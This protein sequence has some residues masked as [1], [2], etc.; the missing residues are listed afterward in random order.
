MLGATLA[1]LVILLFLG[2]Q[3][4]LINS[5]D[6][7]EREE[8]KE[9][10]QNARNSLYWDMEDL[11]KKTADWSV[12]DETYYFVRDNNSNYI[13][14]YLVDET[15][16]NQR[17]SFVLF[18]NESGA[19]V[20][21]KGMDLSNMTQVPP[22]LMLIDHLEENRYLLEHDTRDSRKTG[23]LYLADVP[24]VLTSQPII[25]SNE[26]TPIGG[27]ILMGR[28]LDQAEQDLLSDKTNLSLEVLLAQET[29]DVRDNTGIRLISG[30]EIYLSLANRSIIT[31]S[32]L[33]NDIYGQPALALDVSSPRTIHLQG[34]ATMT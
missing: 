30:E 1:G 25:L 33:L 11:E 17:I 26:D 34:K 14:A 10:M 4:I 23:M 6:H 32:I 8:L 13:N 12:W 19:L 16:I 9:D 15:F 27:V 24:I 31:G 18:Y 7:L 20:Y 29:E 2:S 22:P 5:F 3:V 21:S 28:F